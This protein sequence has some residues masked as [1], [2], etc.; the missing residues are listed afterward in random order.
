MTDDASRQQARTAAYSAGVAHNRGDAFLRHVN[1]D[2]IPRTET[3]DLEPNALAAA[4]RQATVDV[5]EFNRAGAQPQPYGSPRRS[6]DPTAGALSASP[7]RVAELAAEMRAGSGIPEPA[8]S[9]GVDPLAAAMMAHV[10]INT[11]TEG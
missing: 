3:G 11:P 2:V 7:D 9:G 6:A 4:V 10:G 5:P 1:V 8:T